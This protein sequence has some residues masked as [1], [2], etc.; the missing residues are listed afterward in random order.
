MRR[1]TRNER[2]FVLGAAIERARRGEVGEVLDLLHCHMPAL[3]EEVKL[4]LSKELVRFLREEA[5][6]EGV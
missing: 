4:V 6:K 5:K 3:K 1:T 2:C